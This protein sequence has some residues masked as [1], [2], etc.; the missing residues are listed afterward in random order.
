[1]Q[2]LKTII[3]LIL[4]CLPAIS[5]FLREDLPLGD[6]SALH[7]YRAMAL[8]DAL[9]NDGSLYPRF[10]SALVYGYGA[11]LFNFFPPSSYYPTVIFHFF[12]LSW[13]SAWKGTM[14]F[15]VFLAALG[16]YL[17]GKE[18]A[19][20]AGGYITA[21]AYIYAPYALFDTIARGTSSE[22]AAMA[23]IP[24][25]LWGF[26]RL[27]RHGSRK[28]FLIA[29]ISFAAF[30]LMHTLM[31][32]FGTALL[33]I[34]CAALWLGSKEKIRLLW[35][36]GL[37]GILAVLLT[38]FFWWP[39][40]AETDF[41]KIDGVV[42]NL[43]F[44][45][46][47]QSLRNLN[48]VFALPKTADTSQLQPIIPIVFGWPALLLALF[49]W[50][51][52]WRVLALASFFALVV[53][54]QLEA[55]ASLWKIIPLLSYSQFA[56]RTMSMASLALAVL[57]GIGAVQ[58]LDKINPKWLKFGTFCVFIGFIVFYS[59][60]WL[61][62]PSDAIAAESI[63]D[64]QAFEIRTGSLT[65][66]SYS[67]YLPIWNISPPPTEFAGRLQDNPA[68][69]I[70][71]KAWT[72]TSANLL[73]NASEATTLT[74]NW[75]YFPGWEARIDGQTVEVLP[76][77]DSGLVSINI[78]AGQH[79]IRLAYGMTS[80]QRNATIL[81]FSAMIVLV[82]ATVFWPGTVTQYQAESQ[83]FVWIVMA[84]GL[85]IFLT[86]TLI[87]DNIN[88]P[89]KTERLNNGQIAGASIPLNANFGGEIALIGAEVMNPV[90]SG[91]MAEIRL[92]WTPVV[93]LVSADYSSLITLRDIEGN[94][95]AEGGSFYPGDLATSNWQ[96]GF[97]LEEIIDFAIP[98]YTVPGDYTIHV[99]LYQSQSGQLLELR[100]AENNPIGVDIAI[101][102][103]TV[104]RPDSFPPYLGG[105]NRDADGLRLLE[106]NGLPES[107]QVG[108]ELVFNWLWENLAYENPS[109]QLAFGETIVPLVFH[110]EW[111]AGDIWRVYQR[112]YLPASL[113]AGNYQVSVLLNGESIALAK[114]EITE[115][116]RNFELPAIENN[117]TANWQNGI[118][119]LGYEQLENGFAFYWQPQEFIP[120]S[121][122]LFVQVQDENGQI[123]AVSDGVPI[124]WTRPT[125][126]WYPQEIIRTEHR[127]ENLPEI[128]TLLVGW[129]RPATGER[130]FL[131]NGS[132]NL[133]IA[134]P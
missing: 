62:R 25:A 89:F 80:T 41:V 40:I 73:I 134:F 45:D 110:E 36:M 83:Q 56:W 24:F 71:R 64:A 54:L 19:G 90:K 131:D 39:A 32:L 33:L 108:D 102:P 77:G 84:L 7:L 67:E 115:P 59:I 96:Q 1:M 81:S 47:T 68:I 114:M 105:L 17:L 13:V 23:L 11:P 63:A 109:V 20:E 78:P 37:A 69:Q 4:L 51:R 117:L 121:L 15:Y 74:F 30:I 112:I 123:I 104:T 26:S 12:G 82:I 98:A 132:D 2:R 28:N 128:Y 18:I 75:L 66:S 103:I 5:P 127:F 42:E 3:A 58:I 34:F 43:D 76:T 101:S 10:A 6:D 52:D 50:R 21:A 113:S 92:F 29:T 87:I 72:G 106:I 35:Q 111:Q 119:I 85:G 55:S 46:V 129:Y 100:N 91:E 9:R 70:E 27:A 133:T 49:A 38:A 88:S 31:T 48:D 65:L 94:I 60:S 126:G 53:F 120:E 8:D 124:D 79:E 22:Y 16:A 97:Y 93:P 118:Q 99:S 130:I 107:A 61:Y 125:S 116:E 14:I 95:I 44:I 86:K 122:R 57:A